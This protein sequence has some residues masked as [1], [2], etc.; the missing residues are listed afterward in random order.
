MP[1]GD[2]L[3]IGSDGGGTQLGLHTR[4]AGLKEI[5][6]QGRLAIVQRTG[7]ENSS[8]SHFTGQD[9]WG[10]ANPLNPQTLGWLGRYLDTL[11]S[12]VNPLV[13]WDALR[14]IPRALVAANV[15]VPAFGVAYVYEAADGM[16]G[17]ETLSPISARGTSRSASQA[18]SGFTGE[19]SVSR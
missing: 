2:V 12:P 1:A 3:Q 8:R 16:A 17:T 5:Y 6:N 4:L 13:A 10:S 18:A 9:I 14:E 7:Y 11:P 19:G 15:S